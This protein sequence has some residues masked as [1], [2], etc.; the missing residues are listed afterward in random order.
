M[1][2]DKAAVYAG[3]I[4]LGRAPA[5]GELLVGNGS[6][7]DLVPVGISDVGGVVTFDG[8]V[9]VDGALTVQGQVE[10]T[11]GGFKFPDDTVQT[12]AAT[13]FS[14][15]QTDFISGVIPVLADQ[16]YRLVINIPYGCTINETTTRCTSG[17]AT[18]TFKINTTALG[19]TANSVSTSEQVQTHSSANTVATGD[20]IVLTISS[21]S[22]AVFLSFTIKITR[23]LA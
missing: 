3:Q 16:D 4:R 13:A 22:S 14:S 9:S 1:A 18:A 17:T 7:F 12:T 20:D 23:T 21:N 10:S 19:G 11:T 6:D 15:S 5:S 2:D 8:P